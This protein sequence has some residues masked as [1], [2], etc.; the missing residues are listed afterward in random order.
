M[1]EFTKK[2]LKAIKDDLKKLYALPPYNEPSNI[3]ADDG[4]FAASIEG[5]YDRSIKQLS[6]LVGIEK[7]KDAYRVACDEISKL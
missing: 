4:Y 3:L 6:K 2:Q 5:R 7:I 1:A